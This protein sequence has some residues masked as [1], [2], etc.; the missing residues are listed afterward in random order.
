VKYEVDYKVFIKEFD[1]LI[2]K[3]N[4]FWKALEILNLKYGIRED[5]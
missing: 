1:E 3:G 2:K 5:K 4:S